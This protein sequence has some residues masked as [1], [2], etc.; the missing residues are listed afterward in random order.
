MPP[1]VE[2]RLWLREG[3][4]GERALTAAI[5]AVVLTVFVAALVPVASDTG[6]A[7][8]LAGSVAQP[9]Q[10]ASAPADSTGTSPLPGS[11]P[12]VPGTSPRLAG[13]GVVPQGPG[14]TGAQRPTPAP[15]GSI[16]SP[17]CATVQ[18]SAPGVTPKTVLLD[19]ANISLAGP[20]GNSTFDVRPDL[21]KIA[22]ALADDINERGGVACGRKLVLKQYDVNPLDANDS[23]SKCLQMA[24]DKPFLVLNVGAYLG[25]A[26]RQCF[27][28]AKVLELSGTQVDKAEVAS[29][30][31]Y[32]FTVTAVAEQ[33][34][35]AAIFGLA[36]RGMF[37]G[38]KFAKLGLFEDGCDPPVN[39]QIARDLAKVGLK[40]SQ[41]STY[42]LECNVA[43]PPNQIEQGVL[44]HKLDNVT[45]VLLA[46]SET[47][48]QNYVRIAR[49]QNFGPQYLVSDYGSN[50]SGA[51]TQNWG[52]SF[53][54]A[55]GITTSRVG[56]FSSGIRN[57]EE[58]ACD[59]ALRKHGVRGIEAENKDTSA[60]ADCDAF[61]LI[62]QAMSRAGSNPT[63]LSFLHGLSTMGLF[64]SAGLGDGRFTAAGKVTGGDFQREIVYRSSC[65][66]WK[67][68]D[69]TMSPVG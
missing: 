41:I 66:C 63:Q 3:P 44:Q 15:G 10:G 29:S 26:S 55:I 24:A 62:R 31:P 25:P 4:R 56:E 33:M 64:R 35:D 7:S 50:T 36:K 58:V 39:K 5:A 42:V 34:V 17:E 65:G 32:L 9:V 28:K 16:S 57:L 48:G 37:S 69:R 2:L 8:T 20:V 30:Y 23:Q 38:S 1:F 68:I 18:A 13:P 22:Q 67:I 14:T 11:A 21:A 51:G 46:S 6:G 53:D 52:P 12:G 47:N 54:G 59:K 61:W 40:A 19:V 27:V 60:L 45:H 49:G 43:S